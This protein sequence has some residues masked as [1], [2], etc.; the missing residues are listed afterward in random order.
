MEHFEY[1]PKLHACQLIIADEIKRLCD[2]HGIRC[3]MIAGTLLGAVR[4]GGFIPW[5]DD[6]DIGMLREDYDAFLRVAEEELGDRFFLQ[7]TETDE[8]YGLPFAKVLLRNTVLTEATAGSR[9]KKGI[10]VDVFPFDVSPEDPGEARRHE[11]RTYFYKRLL[12]AKKGYNVCGKGEYAKRAV[13]CLLSVLAAFY[14]SR[15]LCRKLQAEI[16]RYN[17]QE[18]A[19]IVNIGGAYGYRKETIRREWVRDTVELPFEDTRLAAPNGYVAYLETFYGDYMTPPP[20]DKRYN[21]HSVVELDF[22]NY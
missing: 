10:F 3:F 7:T 4:H 21:R 16:T 2:K 12:L 11:R 17:G 9:A 13:Y 8:H 1:L 15:G 19:K 6:M 5:D 14:S 18:S 20:E 22:G